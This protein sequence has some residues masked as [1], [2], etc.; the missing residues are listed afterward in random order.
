MK[1][2][3]SRE[4]RDNQKKY[5]D[6]VDQNEQVIVRRSKNRAYKLI[7]VSESDIIMEI[8]EEYRVNP[9][10]YS[11]SGDPF[12]ADK[13]NVEMV[14]SRIKEL[15]EEKDVTY[16]TLRTKEDIENFLDSL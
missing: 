10:N 9:Y 14:K 11:P 6:L 2:I 8:P 5:L 15:V 12:W 1:I 13:R 16:S 3:T 7:P 4:F